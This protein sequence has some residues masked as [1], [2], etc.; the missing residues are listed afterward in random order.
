MIFT[1]SKIKRII[2]EV[3]SKK[4]FKKNVWRT[5]VHKTIWKSYSYE[6]IL[7]NQKVLFFNKI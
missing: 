4:I 5:K 3:L 1:N 2:I 6:N 7:L